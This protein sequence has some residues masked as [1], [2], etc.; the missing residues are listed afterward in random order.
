MSRT[1]EATGLAELVN[2][3]WTRLWTVPAGH[4]FELLD[5]LTILAPIPDPQVLVLF[6]PGAG[7]GYYLTISPT[8]AGATQAWQWYTDGWPFHAGDSL[9]VAVI[10]HAGATGTVAASYIDVDYNT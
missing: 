7:P 10:N 1:L 8:L 3:A 5:L 9:D 2:N 4:K 6:V